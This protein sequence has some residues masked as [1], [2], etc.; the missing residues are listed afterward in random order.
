[1][2]KEKM[3]T[4]KPA[5]ACCELAAHE[6]P[7]LPSVGSPGRILPSTGPK[8]FRVSYLLH[9]LSARGLLAFANLLHQG[10]WCVHPR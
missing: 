3:K 6:F 2:E 10:T 8:C 1:M 5:F 9:G 4:E 7:S